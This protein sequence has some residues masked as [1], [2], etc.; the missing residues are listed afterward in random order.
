MKLKKILD[1]LLCPSNLHRNI[2]DRPGKINE[3]FDDLGLFQICE[4]FHIH[5]GREHGN[6]AVTFISSLSFELAFDLFDWGTKFLDSIT[7]SADTTVTINEDSCF[8][9]PL[10][11]LDD[12][13]K[14]E[15]V[16]IDVVGQI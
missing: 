4:G 2:L 15:A 7:D 13:G 1:S 9:I 6:Q 5:A 12:E 11:T 10:V 3:S 8:I 14:F 16:L